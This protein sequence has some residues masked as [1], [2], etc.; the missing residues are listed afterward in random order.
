MIEAFLPAAALDSAAITLS[1]APVPRCVTVFVCS[2]TLNLSLNSSSAR[3]KSRIGLNEL[4]ATSLVGARIISSA[5]CRSLRINAVSIM[6]A[7]IV[8]LVFFFEIKRKNSRINLRFV[9]GSYAPKIARTNSI[10]HSNVTS[11]ILGLPITST[12]INSLKIRSA[13][14]A[15]LGNNGLHGINDCLETIRVAQS[16]QAVVQSGSFAVI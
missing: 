13:T 7:A 11:P 1:V 14:S 9:L 5:D 6:P 12:R 3:M 2:D 10:T 8:D 16:G 4:S 15:T